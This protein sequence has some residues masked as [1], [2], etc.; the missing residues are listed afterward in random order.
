MNDRMRLVALIGVPLLAVVLYLILSLLFGQQQVL[1]AAATFLAS[2]DRVLGVLVFLPRWASWAVVVFFI[3]AGARFLLWENDKVSETQRSIA[4]IVTLAVLLVAALVPPLLGAGGNAERGAWWRPESHRPA[5]TERVF[6]DM[7]FVWV[8]A[9]HCTMGSPEAEP[10]HTV[11]ERQ[12]EIVFARGFWMSQNEITVDEYVKIMGKPPDEPPSGPQDDRLPVAGVSYEEA[13]NFARELSEKDRATYRLPSES[14]WEYAC[15]AG[16][17]TAWSFG[18][19]P[20]MLED[21]GWYVRN[22]GGMAHQAGT[23]KRNPWK[24]NDMHGNV[25]E[26][27]TVQM[28]GGNTAKYRV[29]RGGYWAAEAVQCRSSARGIYLPG[30]AKTP[31]WTGIR[32]LREP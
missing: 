32:L 22:S 18:D 24:L 20:A 27:C 11:D 28:E 15:R 9:G 1:W 31:T 14:E 7:P 16:T 21:Y 10:G 25:A 30:Q 29:Y 5:G 8:P 23:K 26:W 4:V 3:A 12:R 6:H 19:D 2:L 13:V 17:V